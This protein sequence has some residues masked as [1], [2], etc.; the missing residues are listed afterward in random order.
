MLSNENE[1][2]N[3]LLDFLT[4]H[5]ILTCLYTWL[6]YVEVVNQPLGRVTIEIGCLADAGSIRLP[7]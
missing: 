4:N 5:V 2:K 3:D 7:R 1:K 6:Y